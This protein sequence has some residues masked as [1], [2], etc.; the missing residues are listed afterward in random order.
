MTDPFSD[1]F[2]KIE[3]GM[4]KFKTSVCRKTLNPVWSARFVFDLMGMLNR[5]A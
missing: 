4:Q 5:S 3:L 1:A 2:C